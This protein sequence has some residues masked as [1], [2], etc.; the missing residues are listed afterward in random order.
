MKNL[1]ILMAIIVGIILLL[2]FVLLILSAVV[3]IIWGLWIDAWK[4]LSIAW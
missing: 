1:L 2:P 3:Q 4:V